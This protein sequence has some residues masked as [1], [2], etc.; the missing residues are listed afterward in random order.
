[1]SNMVPIGKLGDC[2]KI[3]T[4]FRDLNVVYPKDNFPFPNIDTLVNNIVRYEMLSLMDRFLGYN[5]IWVD[6]QD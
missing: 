4:N 1:M 3:Y 5:H 2:I 6:P